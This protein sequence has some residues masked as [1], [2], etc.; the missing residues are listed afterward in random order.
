MLHVINLTKALLSFESITPHQAGCLDYIETLLK[1][2]GFTCE[3]FTHEGVDNLYAASSPDHTQPTFC[4]AGHVD[5]VPAGTGWR[6]PPFGGHIEHDIIYG[7]GVVDMKGAISAFIC[8]ALDFLSTALDRRVALLLTSDE[9]GAA[10]HGTRHVL[11]YLTQRQENIKLCVVGEPT[12]DQ[13]VGDTVKVGRRGS[14]SLILSENGEQGH[15]AYPH[16]ADNPIHRFI[17]ALTELSS[18]VLDEG[19]P[20]FDRSVLQVTSID[21]G[22]NV[23]NIIP[24]QIRATLNIRFNPHHTADQLEKWVSQILDRYLKNYTLE[25]LS[26][27]E[28]FYGASP[29]L[30]HLAQRAIGVVTGHKPHLS[31]SGGTSDARFLAPLY[32]VIE[33]GLLNKTAHKIDE[34]CTLSDL[35][36]LQLIYAQFLN[37]SLDNLYWL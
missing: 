30:I 14:L 33:C 21:V 29:E 17:Q 5:V 1:N 36:C 13:R 15:V 10:M 23:S 2:A 12:S 37:L 28:A 32:P 26:A 27:A 35:E 19:M 34:S 22:N 7:R 9:E 25:R 16:L 18:A 31:T 24:S 20:G 6:Y 11:T 4:F 3:R 8:A